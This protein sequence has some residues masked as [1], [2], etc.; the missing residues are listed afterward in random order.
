MNPSA[1][2]PATRPPRGL[3][4]IG[5]FLLFGAVMAFLAGM[6]LGWRGTA[7]DCMWAL[8]P[9]AYS[10]LAPYGKTIGIPFLLLGI[11]LAVAGFGWLNRRIWGWRLAVA[12]IAT[13]V[14][15]NFLNALMGDVVRG[16]VG[17]II[18]GALLVYLLRPEVKAA[19]ISR[20]QGRNKI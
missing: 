11:A 9:R 13:Q 15:G 6:T 10:E 19:F 3:T 8:N 5:L 18:A 1:G 12:I 4:A 17:F 7:L 14:L 20:V 2:L 16:L